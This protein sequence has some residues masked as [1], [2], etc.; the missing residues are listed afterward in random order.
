MN[1]LKV[2]DGLAD[3]YADNGFPSAQ[4]SAE[5]ALPTY[6][7][8]GN[9]NTVSDPYRGVSIE[10]NLLNKPKKILGDGLEIEHIYDATGRKW[11]TIR[12]VNGIYEV[13]DYAGNAILID[14]KLQSVYGNDGR[15]VMEYDANDE[16]SSVRT[17]YFHKDHLGNTRLAFSDLN[18]DGA[19]T[20]TG[21]PE[22]IQENH[23]YPF[24]MNMNGYWFGTVTP[25]NNFQYNGIE[26]EESLNLN[27][28]Y[29]RTLDPTIGRWLQSDPYAHSFG[30]ETPYNSMLNNP[31]NYVDPGGGFSVPGA[32]AGA[33][34]G[35]I[36]GG[37][38]DEFSNGKDKGVGAAVGAVTGALLG[39]FSGQ[40]SGMFS[41]RAGAAV[42]KSLSAGG[43]KT[44]ALNAVNAALHSRIVGAFSNTSPAT[45]DVYL[46][47]SSSYDLT[48]S[49]SQAK[50][51]L[52]RNG[53]EKN[54]N[55]HLVTE[56]EVLNNFPIQVTHSDRTL[57][58]GFYNIGRFKALGNSGIHNIYGHN[59]IYG[60]GRYASGLDVEDFQKSYGSSWEYYLGLTIAH[61][62]A[63][64]LDAFA[65][66]SIN[67]NLDEHGF[68]GH[69][70]GKANNNLLMNGQSFLLGKH[71]PYGQH[72]L[73]LKAQHD[74]IQQY[75]QNK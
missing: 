65:L 31:M 37:M 3:V 69:Y 17:D 70:G 2:K 68:E 46:A 36:V 24:G 10:Y 29:H 49:I 54:V 7:Y 4:I 6:S 45:I 16:I 13:Q 63:H 23:Y 47:N 39:G 26:L 51:I 62:L 15:F 52:A 11:R 61:E 12:D 41:G 30:S 43:A 73:L 72:E 25:Q 1:L 60:G 59:D 56:N 53:I 34:I 42:T 5:P 19:I 75:Y 50:R 14:G 57:F 9:G 38:I 64:Q 55:F 48:T 27:F 18:G 74:I 67:G 40:L 32:I 21:N 8:D 58:L 35:A 33:T 20:I 66:M 71:K 44:Y 28:A 22:I